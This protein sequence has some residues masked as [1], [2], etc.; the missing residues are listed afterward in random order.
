MRISMIVFFLHFFPV[1]LYSQYLEQ[2]DVNIFIRS[3]V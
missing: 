2:S 3:G 1:S